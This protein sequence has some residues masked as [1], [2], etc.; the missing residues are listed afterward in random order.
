[1]DIELKHIEAF[2]ADDKKAIDEQSH[3]ILFTI[4]EVV[5]RD[6]EIVTADAIY[7][8]LIDKEN[9]AA[10]PTCQ[11]GHQSRLNDG[12]PPC[13][14]SWDVATAQ[15]I[16]NAVRIWLNYAIG[17]NPNQL[18]TLGDYYW[19]AYS[20][21]HMRAV[22]I[23]FQALEWRIEDRNGKQ[24]RVITKIILYEISCVSVGANQGALAKYKSIFN[25]DEKDGVP[26]K[27]KEYL[28]GKFKELQ[29]SFTEQIED[30]KA[31]IIPDSDELAKSLLGRDNDSLTPAEE[32]KAEQIDDEQIEKAFQGLNKGK[33]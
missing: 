15:K 20:Q 24:I 21:R 8:A 5:D 1:M 14:G 13:V 18:T 3:R 22:S 19:W 30:L 29:D 25:F 11:P 27:A 17:P 26:Q 7:N 10:N 23:G 6:D 2:I 33:N 31:L 4:P 12:K 16:T 32:I 28:D 9:F